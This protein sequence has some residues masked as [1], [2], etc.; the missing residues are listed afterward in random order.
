MC[1]PQTTHSCALEITF[2]RVCRF[3]ASEGAAKEAVFLDFIESWRRP[4]SISHIKCLLNLY[5]WRDNWE[6][7]GLFDGF[8]RF[9]TIK[10]IKLALGSRIS[11]QADHHLMAAHCR[12]LITFIHN[13]LD[14]IKLIKLLFNRQIVQILIVFI[15]PIDSLILISVHVTLV[16]ILGGCWHLQLTCH[17]VVEWMDRS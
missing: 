3:G 8:C 16:G 10:H 5:V 1:P 14:L 4:A 17:L 9:A 11:I 12:M 6:F 13:L 15:L 2:R 7:G